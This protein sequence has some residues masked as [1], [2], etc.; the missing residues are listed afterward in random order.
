MNS[1]FLDEEQI[2]I[3]IEKLELDTKE[4]KINYDNIKNSLD[5]LNSHYK[6]NNTTKLDN[7]AFSLD[8]KLKTIL[9]IHDDNIIVLRKNLDTYMTTSDKISKLFD[10]IA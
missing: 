2:K 4:E 1:N 9:K 7:I 6:T 5:S 8:N 3:T 10:D